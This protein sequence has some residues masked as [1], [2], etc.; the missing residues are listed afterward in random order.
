MSFQLKLSLLS[1][2][3]KQY[4]IKNLNVKPTSTI[5]D[6]YPMLHKCYIINKHNDTITLPLGMWKY[7]LDA[8]PNGYQYDKMNS[9]AKF[10]KTLL[11]VETD[12]MKKGRD[13][14]VIIA[15]AINHLQNDGTVFM[16]LPCGTGKSALSIYLSIF[17][18]YK[19]LILTH[20]DIIKRQWIDEYNNFSDGS[21]KV[22]FLNKTPIVIDINADVY[23][24][25]IQ[26]CTT[27]N[28]TLF[29]FIGTVIVDEAHIVTLT[30]FT[31]CLFKIKP[32]YL[33]GLSATPDRSDGLHSLF[34]FYFGH[35]ENYIIRKEKKPFTVY[36][37][38]TNYQ[39]IIKFVKVN[40][41]E[42]I[43][44]NTIVNSIEENEERW[45]IIV[46]IIKYHPKN[47]IIVL[48]N[49]KVLTRGIYNLLLQQH[50]DAELLIE[51]IKKWD[52]NK[53]ILV[54][55]FKKGGVGMN[56]PELDMAIIASDTKDVR[57]YEGR[58][59]TTNNIIYHIVDCYQPFEKHY[60]EC[61]DWYHNKGGIIVNVNQDYIMLRLYYH[62]YFLLKYLNL[63]YDIKNLILNYF[64]NLLIS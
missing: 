40:R 2:E 12:P 38:K 17:L 26:K 28:T 36:K 61:R 53:K 52:K 50:F 22:Q 63:V 59:R 25:G 10:T 56:D 21:V 47:K 57:Q 64:I 6:P 33:I 49:R 16:C 8:F 32:R 55:S 35:Q 48:C 19:T 15:D 45:Q 54:T 9:K 31:Q 44:W 41:K 3:N 20:L 30:A 7:Y 43:D 11:T 4:I 1:E 46:D 58:I 13:Q 34:N 18:G 37:V 23:I 60:K 24:I 29:D 14:D 51:N 42:T 39:P 5:Y 62:H 27:I